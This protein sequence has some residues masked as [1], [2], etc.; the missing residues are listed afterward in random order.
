MHNTK[1][2]EQ[3][4]ETLTKINEGIQTLTEKRSMLLESLRHSGNLMSDKGRHK[5]YH[6]IDIATSA[7]IRLTQRFNNLTRKIV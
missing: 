5:M 6:D 3:I 1:K 4:L 7:K 2:V